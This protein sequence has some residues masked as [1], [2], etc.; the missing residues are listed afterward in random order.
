MGWREHKPT[1]QGRF[2]AE[3]LS[4]P[5]HPAGW[6]LHQNGNCCP[7]FSHRQRKMEPRPALGGCQSCPPG[8][9]PQRGTRLEPRISATLRPRSPAFLIPTG[10]SRAG[11]DASA[12]PQQGRVGMQETGQAGDCEASLESAQRSSPRQ[13]GVAGSALTPPGPASTRTA[14]PA[15]TA[16]VRLSDAPPSAHS[17]EAGR[18]REGLGQGG[19]GG[20]GPGP[21]CRRQVGRW[22]CTGEEFLQLPASR[23]VKSSQRLRQR[24]TNC[25]YYSKFRIRK[26]RPKGR[27]LGLPNCSQ[28]GRAGDVK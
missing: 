13:P 23:F 7:E 15:W 19:G 5:L 24:W 9:S 8:P 25:Y 16:P 10:A 3:I 14:V 20:S 18:P 4:L 11:Q 6:G 12:A 28:R 1:R 17:G 26:L 22:E 21:R 2:P 27:S